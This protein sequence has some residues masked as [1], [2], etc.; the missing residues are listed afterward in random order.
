MPI[1]VPALSW[2][3]LTPAIN[4]IPRAPRFLQDMI[5][6]TR[7][8]NASEYVDVDVV[9]GGR[10]ILP[11]ISNYAGGTIIDKMTGQMRSVKCPRLRPKK[12]LDA[13]ELLLQRAAG[14]TIYANGGSVAA[15]RDAKIGN[16]LADIKNRVDMTVEYMC[17]M[18]LTGGYTV[19]QDDYTF[20]I[21]FNMPSANKPV[22]TT[23]YGWNQSETTVDIMGDIDDFAQI[24]KNATGLTPD[25]AICGAAVVKALRGNTAV[26]TLLDNRRVMAGDVSWDSNSDY[27]GTLNGI[28]LFKAGQQYQTT[29]GVDADFID[30]NKFVLL[31]TQARF[32]IEFGLILDLDAG[33]QIV[34]EYFAKTWLEKDPSALWML[35]ESR[36]LP[37]PWQPDAIVYAD[38]IV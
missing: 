3:T 18:A 4:Q 14:Q 25:I 19:T 24:I 17:A 28:K 34:G 36:P 8:A 30:D 20:T 10:K 29:A 35:A 15:S 33:S 9:V 32:T 6:K 21:D 23:G 37:I 1:T 11:F 16:E 26:N 22:L 31:S 2:R 7:N 13:A 38:V 5:F 12:Q 27:I